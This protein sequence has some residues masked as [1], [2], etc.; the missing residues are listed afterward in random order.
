M[1]VMEQYTV[2]I[3]AGGTFVK[4]GLFGANGHEL[5]AS[6]ER[7][8]HSTSSGGRREQDP[9]A[10]FGAV[11]SAAQALL[12]SSGIGPRD[13][14]AISVTGYGSGLWLVDEHGAALGNGILSTDVRTELEPA[15]AL[16]EV[17]A[18]RVAHMVSQRGW[19]G[20]TAA[21]LRWF[22]EHEPSMLPRVHR[23]LAC[24]DFIRSRLCGDMSTDHTDAGLTGLC[25]IERNSWSEDALDLLGLSQWR[26]VLPSI[27]PGAEKVGVVTA[28]AAELTGFAVGTPVIRGVVDVAACAV[29]SR[30]LDRSHMSVVAGTFGI[31][32][33][34]HRR[35]R[36]S[37]PPLL[38]CRYVTGEVYLA[39]EGGITS[40]SNLEWCCRSLFGGP[41]DDARSRGGDLYRMCDEAVT[42]AYA[43]DRLGDMMFFPYLFGGPGGAPAGLLGAVAEDGFDE[44]ALAVYEG[45]AY[46]HRAD[47]ESL[48]EGEDAAR[49][50]VVRMSGGA[51][52]SPIWPQIFADVL[53]LRVDVADRGE[54]GVRG[55]AITAA[56][57]IGMFPEF[58]SAASAFTPTL[59]SYE[60][61]PQQVA[62]MAVR[63]AR[64]RATTTALAAVWSRGYSVDDRYCA[65]SVVAADA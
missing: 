19:S 43:R 50:G 15:S 44:A 41:A 55:A 42:R 47:I 56:V 12:R 10:L 46:A 33:T 3:D 48:L 49:P 51:S 8:P 24:K 35:P 17:T 26:A 37:R 13:I 40:A 6:K 29:A 30:V 4:A 64:H 60:P 45:I 27:G 59:R 23:V 62:V 58:A 11:C 36:T 7:S 22:D 21:L 16:D 61:D 25:D 34:L 57:G 14:A 39:S 1:V 9:D 52:L 65:R 32:Q 38:Q 5:A 54:I 53:G 2:G 28:V 63:Y 20:Q 18:A 31:D